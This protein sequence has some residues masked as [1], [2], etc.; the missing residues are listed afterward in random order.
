MQSDRSKK[1][2][3]W[4]H[5]KREDKESINGFVYLPQCTCSNCEQRVNYENQFVHIVGQSWMQKLQKIQQSTR[6][7][8]FS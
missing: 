1:H 4:I 3:Y 7:S 5:F 6:K 8:A 2:A